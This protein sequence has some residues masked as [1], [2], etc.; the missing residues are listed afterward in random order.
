[1]DAE[2]KLR[3]LVTGGCGKIGSYFVRFASE[4]YIIRVV[5][6]VA[7]DPERLGPFSVES[8]VADLQDPTACRQ[9]CEG[10]DMV[11]H[12]A[13]DASPE[14]DFE[15]SLLGNNII[16]TYNMFRAAREA[17][18]RRF[19]YASSVHAVAAYPPDVQIKVNMPVRPTNLYGV[20]KCFGE[21]LAAHFAFNEGLPGIALRIGAYVFPEHPED[22][23]PTEWDAFLSPD[24]FND[25]LVRCLETPNITFAIAHVISDNKFK[26][27]D[28][29]ETKEILGYQPKADAFELFKT[30]SKNR[31]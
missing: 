16:A 22:L 10:M 19:I 29:T 3:V 31:G 2:S 6:K 12:L 14:A 9:A 28:L 30:N 26:R 13:A 24:D 1:M 20:S 8:L 15:D 18:C 7:W 11:V 27:L 4:K 23:L 25:L 21:A 5:D 17:G